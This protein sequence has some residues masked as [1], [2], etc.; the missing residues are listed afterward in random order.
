MTAEDTSGLNIG[1]RD[2]LL[3]FLF[4]I[5][6]HYFTNTFLYFLNE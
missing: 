1:I 4:M 3:N 6:S 2:K 5:L